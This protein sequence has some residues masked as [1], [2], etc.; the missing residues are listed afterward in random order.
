MQHLLLCCAWGM[1]LDDCATTYFATE[2]SGHVQVLQLWEAIF[3]T[4]QD[5]CARC[6]VYRCSAARLPA[7]T[8]LQP[9]G[10]TMD[11]PSPATSL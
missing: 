6:S 3:S 4:T 2:Q 10:Q 9:S 11:P 5:D 7:E 1:L 8:T